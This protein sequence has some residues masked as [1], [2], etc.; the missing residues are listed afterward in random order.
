MRSSQ[1]SDAMKIRHA[2]RSATFHRVTPSS[3]GITKISHQ[4]F[5]DNLQRH[6]QKVNTSVSNLY[7]IGPRLTS[8]AISSGK[9]SRF[10]KCISLVMES[11]I[12]R[13][14]AAQSPNPS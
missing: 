8:G 10:Q 4:N 9:T 13:L 5:G 14:D 3:N 7:S 12:A 2:P 1:E 11:G 6:P